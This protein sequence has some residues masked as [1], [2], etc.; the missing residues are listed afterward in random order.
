MSVTVQQINDLCIKNK[1]L[2]TLVKEQLQ[3]IDDKLLHSD[4][5]LGNNCIIHG[6]PTM[7]PGIIGI[8]KKD[9]QRI[10]YSSIICSLEKRGFVVKI[11]LTET[12][13][14]LYVSWKSELSQESVETMNTIIKDKLISPDELHKLVYK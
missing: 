5:S 6:L 14:I 13:S 10:I 7:M 11:A 3:I 4:R 2:D 9:A 12:S 1:D 8:D